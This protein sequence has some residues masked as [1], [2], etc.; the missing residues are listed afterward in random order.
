M[1]CWSWRWSWWTVFA[2]VDD[3][4][5]RDQALPRR[6]A[7]RASLALGRQPCSSSWAGKYSYM[8]QL[9]ASIACDTLALIGYKNSIV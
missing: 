3:F 7:Q 9:L 5:F 6:R 1:G 2:F 8:R 4:R